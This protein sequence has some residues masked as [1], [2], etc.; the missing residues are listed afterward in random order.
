MHRRS[1]G[2]TQLLWMFG[3]TGVLAFGCFATLVSPSLTF[4]AQP[5]HHLVLVFVTARILAGVLFVVCM[6]HVG[7]VPDTRLWMAIIIGVGLGVRGVLFFSQPVLEDDYNRYLLDG[8]LTAHGV[9]PFRYSPE[10]ILTGRR[11]SVAAHLDLSA[12]GAEDVVR[13]INHPGIRTIYPP[14]SQAVF[15]V[16]YLVAPWKLWGWKLLILMCDSLVLLLLLRI[17]RALHLPLPLAAVYW[18]NPVVIHEFSNALHMDV[19]VLPGVLLALML[20]LRV[21]TT[22]GVSVL[23]LASGF[24]VWPALLLPLFARGSTGTNRTTLKLVLLG[25]VVIAVVFIP[26]LMTPLN[27]SLGLVKYA[28][29]WTNNQSLFTV[30][31]W[32]IAGLAAPFTDSRDLTLGMTRVVTGLLIIGIALRLASTP[33]Q[34]ARDLVHRALVTVAWL[35]FLSPTQFPWYYTWMVPLLALSLRPSL[36]LYAATLPLFQLVYRWEFLVWIQHAPV[37]LIFLWEIRSGKTF[38]GAHE[39]N[40]SPSL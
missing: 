7:R 26:V 14:F 24:K 29:S 32:V 9:N 31:H 30:L 39:Q 22:A 3:A 37:F 17:L 34:N 5:P 23:A 40:H 35:F 13:G 36:L 33:V 27:E 28:S 10:E 1:S 25:A 6:L 38:T 16:A 2:P 12:P 8:A 19:L 4:Q 21:R 15:A 11:D 18:W 20:A